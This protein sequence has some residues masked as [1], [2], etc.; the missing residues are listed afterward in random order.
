M[1]R[2]KLVIKPSVIEEDYRTSVERVDSTGKS[3]LP[4]SLFY[5]MTRLTKDKGSL[6]HDDRLDALSIGVNYF[7]ERLAR[8]ADRELERIKDQRHN[9][10]LAKKRAGREKP[11]VKTG[12]LRSS[13]G[14]SLLNNTYKIR[15]L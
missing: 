1:A 12:Y 11:N 4:Y 9:K 3:K 2:H 5:Q 8:D 15:K 13:D 10:W 14:P 7:T 6:I